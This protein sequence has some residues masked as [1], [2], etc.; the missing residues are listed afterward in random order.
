MRTATIGPVFNFRSARPTAGRHCFALAVLLAAAGLAQAGP[1][2][3]FVSRGPGGGGAFFGPSINPFNPTEAWIGSDM[4]DLFHTDDFGATWETVDFRVL[5]GGS[6]PGRMEFTSNPLVRYALNSDVPA[7]SLDGGV[8]WTSIPPDPWSQSVY[9]LYADPLSTNRLLVSDYTTLKISTNSGATYA[10]CFTSN[11]L[12]IAGAFWDG[13]RIYVGTRPGLLVSTNGGASFALA[14]TTGIPATEEMVSFAGAKENGTLRFF[15]ITFGAG[16]VWPGIQGSE[17]WSY[18][19]LYRLDGGAGA[20]TVATNGVADNHL[21]FV[22]MCRTNISIAYAAGSDSAG[23]PVVLKT[24]NGGG[25]WAQVMQCTGNANVATGWTGDDPGGWNWKKWS[26][27]ECAMGFTVCATDPNRAVISDFGFIH[28]TTNGGA[29]WRQAYDWQGCENPA[30]SPTPKTNFFTGCGAEDTSCWWLSWFSSNSMFCSFTDIRGMLS[31]NAGAA[32]MSPLSLSYN[33]TYQ[34]LK[35]PSNGLVYAGVS[36]V[37]DLYAWDRYCQDSAID[38]GTGE[39]LFSANQGA[40]WARLKNLGKPVVALALDP[41]NTNRLYAAVVNSTNGGIYRTV[42]LDAGTA[43]TWTR[44]AVPPRTQ[45]HPCSIVVLNDGTLVAT[46]SARIASGNFQ[47]SSGVFV[48]TTDGA[49]WV[50]RGAPGQQ[51]YTKDLTVDPHDPTQST[52]Y[53]GVWGEWGS[54]A[55]LGGL[56]GTTNRGLN[57][58]RLTTNLKAVGSCAVNPV[59]LDELYVATEDQGLWYSANRRAATPTF[60]QLAGYPFRFPTRIFFNPCNTN[61]VWVTSFGNGMRLGRV[62]EPKPSLRLQKTNLISS[63]T[64]TAAPGQRVVLSAS[65]NLGAWTPLSTNVMFTGQ[66][67]FG[68]TSAAGV[69]FFRADVP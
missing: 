69:R 25:S 66:W 18:L 60:T 21:F 2:A 38:G 59:N 48:S 52:W 28:V 58:T 5:G 34:T 50:D 15:C 19:K 17:Y 47:P 30:G 24:V 45:G 3:R 40:T 6:Q 7:R 11:D 36:S 9:C 37:H 49:S 64:V 26:F 44:L 67:N 51:Y 23:Q 62:I 39:V 10:D 29:T 41:N 57:W 61:E 56:Y 68:E 16:N 14:A 8:T 65:P 27:G 46:Y 22:A 32:W 20:W 55:G 35:H 54:S 4:S 13:P 1:P 42:N 31:T 43:S 33:S 12:L 53:T 63:L